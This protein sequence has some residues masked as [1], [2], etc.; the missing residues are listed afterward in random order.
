MR[1]EEWSRVKEVFAEALTLPAEARHAYLS[2]ACAGDEALRQDV[3]MLLASHERAADFLESP[4]PVPEELSSPVNLEG[5]RIG[6]YQF[7]SRIGSGGMGDVYKA[8]D[9][10]LDRTVAIKVL[11]LRVAGDAIARERFEREARAVAALNHPHICTLHDIGSDEGVD[12][13]VMEYLDGESM[14]ARLE[15]G[16]LSVKRA[17][18]YAIQIASALDKVHRAG[19]VHRDLKPGN[20]MITKAGAKLLDF[21]LSNASPS[22]LTTETSL[23]LPPLEITSSGIILGTMQYMA[24]EQLEGKRAD[25]RSDIFAFGAVLYEMIAGSKAFSAASHATLTLAIREREPAALAKA[26]PSIDR[27]IR[28]CLAKDPDDRWQTA[29]DLLRELT[30]ISDAGIDEAVQRNKQPRRAR[31]AWTA[32]AI[33]MIVASALAVFASL[34]LSRPV[35]RSPGVRFE[36][37]TPPTTD[38]MSLALSPD[39][40]QLAFVASA[41]GVSKLW[42]RPLDQLSAQPLAGTDG[43]GYP[44]WAP[45]GRAIGFFAGGKL[46][47]LDLGESIPLVLA[48]AATARGGT[49]NSDGVIVFAPTTGGT[50]SRVPAGGGTTSAVTELTPGHE[51]HRWP[52]FLPDGRHFLFLSTHGARGTHG[53]FV[54]SLDSGQVT[55][56]SDDDAPPTFV[57][58]DTLL[59]IRQGALVALKFDA[60]RHEV[61]GDARTVAQ[62]IGFD[63]STVHG[64]FALSATGVLA[65]RTAI[66]ERRQLVWVHRD[67][68]TLGSIGA[69]D[70]EAMAAPGL[71]R[72]ARRIAIFRTV[73]GNTDVWLM[74]VGGGVPS[75]FT[76]HAKADM[77]PVMS[78]QDDRVVFGSN[79]D[80]N[81]DLFER[82]VTGAVD[83]KPLLRSAELKVPLHFSPDGRFLLY[84]TQARAT[85]VDMWALPM[86]GAR[87]PFAVQQTPFDE[88]AGQFSPD[89]RWIAYQSN[90]SGRMEVYIAPFPGP[91]ERQQV[92]AAGGSQPRWR[93]D[94]KELFYIASDGRMM[95]LPTPVGP[96]REMPDAGT[97]A[98]LFKIRLATGANVPPSAGSRAQYDVAPDGRFLINAAVEGAAAPPITIALNW[99]AA[100]QR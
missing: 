67:G 92:S 42:V 78:P 79:R 63:A 38:P 33:A 10:R 18:E 87:I 80:G 7:G 30:W 93:L 40:R 26:P 58:P 83:E 86:S 71:T 69:P 75:R 59:T 37:T 35:S 36:V 22:P 3:E 66:A 100:A 56:V 72:D 85:G 55:R 16:A 97:P 73:E 62:P 24:P 45:D 19:I 61:T 41:D 84:A 2:G 64:A 14:A 23:P 46:K 65:Y 11:P 31:L 20:I 99:Q 91:G 43:A 88:M 17:L 52:Q 5:T 90:A 34:R 51:S 32:A 44:F 27:V 39:G 8:R 96:G 82:A 12:F 60:S 54:G 98:P 49:W 70:D 94:A 48:D 47:R 13:L 9:M 15:R 1:P 50:L 53:L 25:A 68:T 95:A 77:F 74:Q 29:R 76:F 57:P 4:A 28:T 6:P 81:Y 89:G 21:G